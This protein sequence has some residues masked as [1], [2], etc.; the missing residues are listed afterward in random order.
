MLGDKKGALSH[1]ESSL[2]LDPSNPETFYFAGK[3][4]NL[5]GDRQEA[6]K[7]LEKSVRAGYSPAEIQNTVELDALR[8]DHRFQALSHAV[9]S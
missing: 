5:L 1:L 6:L 2:R 3:V 4:Y 9:H 7:W 8:G